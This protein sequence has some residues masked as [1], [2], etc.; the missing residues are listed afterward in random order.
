LDSIF[1]YFTEVYIE[2]ST[3]YFEIIYFLIIV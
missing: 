3:E 1:E 2:P